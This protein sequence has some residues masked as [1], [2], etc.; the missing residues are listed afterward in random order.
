VLRTAC[1]QVKVWHAAGYPQLYVAV[2]TS[3]RQF[4]G[5]RLLELVPKI[6]YETDLEPQFLELE[7][8]EQ[9]AVQNSGLT[10]ETV[11]ELS[12]LGVNISIDDFGT[13]SFSLSELKC[14]PTGTIKIDCSSIPGV[15]D[16]PEK[17]ETTA[18]IIARAHALN[19]NVIAKRVETN[20]QLAF[21]AAQGC[22]QVQGF[23]ISQAIP[24]AGLDDFL[25]E[26]AAIPI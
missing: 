10:M 15:F 14:L 4:R 6:L 11:C 25:R 21:A 19:L 3:T 12:Q 9:I 13:D 23:L 17:S 1:A 16:E 20:E 24:A 2:N 5:Q 18:A 7:V 8:S 26:R 22:D